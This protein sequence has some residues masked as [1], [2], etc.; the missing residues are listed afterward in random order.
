M[1][2]LRLHWFDVGIIFAVIVAGRLPVSGVQGVKLILWLNLISLFLHQFE[3]YRYP[4]YFPGMLNTIL[5]S[6]R[7]PDRYPLNTNSSFVINVA[8]GWTIY[9]MAAMFAGK[10]IWLGIAAFSVSVGNVLAHAFLFNIRGRT[11]YNPGLFTSVVLFLPLAAFFFYSL[12]KFGIAE[13]A[14]WAA[15]IVLGAILNYVGIFKT[16]EWMKDPLTTYIFPK[17][18][19]LPGTRSGHRQESSSGL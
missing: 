18:C 5:F 15:G 8:L 7:Q 14:D 4:G 11:F 19:I 9:L 17:R 2:F 1:K 6:S 13:P 3:E 16:I 10:A 12:V